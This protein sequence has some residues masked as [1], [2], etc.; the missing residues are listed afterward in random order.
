MRVRIYYHHTDCGGV[1]YYA[2]YLKFLEEARTQFMEGK[3]V[4]IKDLIKQG[5]LFVVCRQEID[6]KSQ[7]LYVLGKYFRSNNG[8]F[9][10]DKKSR[11]KTRIHCQDDSGLR[12]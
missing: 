1:V 7:A 5:V 12:G 10:R 11:R 8:I 4:F 9:L 2:N 3:G 6:Y